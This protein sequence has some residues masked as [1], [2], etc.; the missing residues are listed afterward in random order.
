LHGA[1]LETVKHNTLCVADFLI[2]Q[3]VFDVGT[4][5]PTQLDD[6]PCF[7]VLLNGSVATKVLL[8]GLANTLDVEIIRQS[9]NSC[10]TLSTISLLHTN[11]YFFFRRNAALVARVLKG[12]C[13]KKRGG[14]R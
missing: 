4:L 13:M 8:E 2:D 11:V 10:N 1:R 12:I 9:R 3:K 14:N 5:I 6:L 7:L